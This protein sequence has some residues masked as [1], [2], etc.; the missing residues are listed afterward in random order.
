MYFEPGNEDSRWSL[1]GLHL[2]SSEPCLLNGLRQN[3]NLE[4]VPSELTSYE[5]PPYN[6][7]F[8]MEEAQN[9]LLDYWFLFVAVS[10]R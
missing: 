9:A 5:Q 2:E 3:R 6:L 10:L 7:S 4:A 8:R 1:Y